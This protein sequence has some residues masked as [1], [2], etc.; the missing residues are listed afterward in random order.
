M[1]ATNG[2]RYTTLQC[3][4]EIEFYDFVDSIVDVDMRGAM[5]ERQKL[6]H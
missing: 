3:Q 6:F 4:A 1:K 5:Y 2:E